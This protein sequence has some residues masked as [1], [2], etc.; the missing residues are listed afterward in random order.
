MNKEKEKDSFTEKFHV[1]LERGETTQ[2]LIM[3]SYQA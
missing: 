1:R 2:I 3:L